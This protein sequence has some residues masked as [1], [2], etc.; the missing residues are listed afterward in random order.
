MTEGSDTA[1]VRLHFAS[2]KTV[3]TT[4]EVDDGAVF[5]DVDEFIES[6]VKGSPDSANHGKPRWTWIGDVYCYTQAIEGVEIL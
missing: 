2:G 1:L 5:V 4:L 6:C 3:Q